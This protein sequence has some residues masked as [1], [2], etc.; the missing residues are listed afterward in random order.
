ME[1]MGIS[2]PQSK[3]RGAPPVLKPMTSPSEK[4]TATIIPSVKMLSATVAGGANLVSK[5]P[6][7]SG[8]FADQG[9]GHGRGIT[10]DCGKHF[11]FRFYIFYIFK[12]SCCTSSFTF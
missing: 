9:N 1:M 2:P 12:K 4:S 6:L 8:V 7:I 5:H 3:G 11:H 10:S